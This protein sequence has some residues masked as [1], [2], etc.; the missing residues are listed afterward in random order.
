MIGNENYETGSLLDY[1]YYKNHYKLVACNLSKQKMLD[2]N[3][4]AAQQ[5]EFI[6]KLDSTNNNTV[7][8]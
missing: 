2:S 7:Q 8:I 4:R 1:A 3:P 5:I 6:F